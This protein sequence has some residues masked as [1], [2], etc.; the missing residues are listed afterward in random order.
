[1]ETAVHQVLLR[2]SRRR[3][4]RHD[5]DSEAE[6]LDALSWL[7]EHGETR[8]EPLLPLVWQQAKNLGVL[9]QLPPAQ[10][11][12]LQQRH[13][14]LAA[15]TSCQRR[16]LADFS[17]R[18]ASRSLGFAPI[19]G[20]AFAGTLYE[21]SAPRPGNDVDLLVECEHFDE[22]CALVREE[23][24]CESES[25]TR[26]ESLLQN[27]ERGF[28][29]RAPIPFLVEIHRGLTQ[30]HLVEI[31][32]AALW[33]R[34]RAYAPLAE[35]ENV[36]RLSAEDELLGLAVHW[37]RHIGL[38]PHNLLDAHELIEEE[39][40]D[41]QAT[42]ARAD[43]WGIR[44]ALSHFLGHTREV[45]ATDIPVEVLQQLQPAPLRRALGTWV[46]G[47]VRHREIDLGHPA[48]RPIQILSHLTLAD[49]LGNVG[50]V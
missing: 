3:G 33:E 48:F 47:H 38:I 41:W 39:E 20:A 9:E 27:Y 43:A 11:E 32:E 26:P 28:M 29:V 13:R 15:L 50:R 23:S 36:L 21:P 19:K 5:G 4:T 2:L 18:M 40:I 37:F 6:I 45:L 24:L 16:W 7:A 25:V 8:M 44:V 31:D 35:H 49:R 22:I 1:M 34:S 14:Y 42:V 17:E 10:Q 30:P 12:V 46:L